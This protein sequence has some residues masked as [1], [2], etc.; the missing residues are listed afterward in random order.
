MTGCSAGATESVVVVPFELVKIRLQDRNSAGKYKGPLDCVAQIIRN[1]GIL[2][3]YNGMEATFWR[4]VWTYALS[5]AVT[6]VSYVPTGFRHVTWN[7]GYFS[8]IFSVR[9]ALPKAE[10]SAE[11]E[12]LVGNASVDS[13]YA[14]TLL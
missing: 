1:E 14:P 5:V 10:V 12:H 4:Y 11:G 8:C 7:G 13:A 6:D 2:G 9:A 3:M